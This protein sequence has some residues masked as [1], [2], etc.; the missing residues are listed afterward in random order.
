MSECNPCSLPIEPKSTSASFMKG[1]KF[2][3]PY[4][5]LI[6]SLLYL[7]YVSRPDVL[8]AVNCLSQIQKN[9]TD[10]AWC[11]LKKLL[12]YLK[13]TQAFKIEYKRNIT[14]ESNLSMYVDA[15]WVSNPK[16]RKSITGYVIMYC[17]NPIL[18]R[19]NKQNCI[20]LSSTEAEV[21]ALCKGVQDLLPLTNFINEIIKVDNIIIFEDNQSCIKCVT[22]EN[23]H[24]RLKHI[25]IKLKY[26]RNAITEN[27]IKVSYIL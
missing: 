23:S 22:N 12:R 5:E 27:D 19:C 20:A 16:D 26:I 11:A 6:G 8:F 14:K 21:L 24:G 25:D 10:V 9:P 17:N 18:W 7:A 3:G 4:R 1:D 13:G 15:D 2:V